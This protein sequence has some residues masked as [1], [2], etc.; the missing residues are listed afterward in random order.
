M[1]TWAFVLRDGEEIKQF[2]EFRNDEEARQFVEAAAAL[3][4][5]PYSALRLWLIATFRHLRDVDKLPVEDILRLHPSAERYYRDLFDDA[6]A[7]FWLQCTDLGHEVGIDFLDL[8]FSEKASPKLS[9]EMQALVTTVFLAHLAVSIARKKRRPIVHAQLS[10]EEQTTLW[11][12]R[13]KSEQ[14]TKHLYRLLEDVM[15]RWIFSVEYRSEKD[16]RT[17]LDKDQKDRVRLR[18][19]EAIRGIEPKG[20]TWVVERETGEREGEGYDNVDAIAPKEEARVIR[21]RYPKQEEWRSRE[22]DLRELACLMS[23]E[24]SGDNDPIDA[25]GETGLNM[26]LS[27]LVVNLSPPEESTAYHPDLQCFKPRT[28]KE[29]L[30]V[31]RR[32]GQRVI[33]RDT[34]RA[35]RFAFSLDEE[36]MAE[37]GEMRS[38]GAIIPDPMTL[39]AEEH[40]LQ[41]IALRE[42]IEQLSPEEQ[43][44]VLA[45]NDGYADEEIAAA[46]GKSKGAVKKRRQRALKKLKEKLQ[47]PD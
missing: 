21:E 24:I 4:K 16:E 11:L 14:R 43:M 27:V 20:I 31:A 28:L 3:W 34:D 17:K 35:K 26:Y 9:L 25:L 13:G 32:Y 41:M 23:A 37:D 44:I 38:R 2:L 6:T 42:A 15:K 30:R 7:L 18:F 5:L 19:L 40:W 47:K 45:H 46:L 33:W 10:D 8:I 12:A 22:L 39:E 36:I 1:L 29:A